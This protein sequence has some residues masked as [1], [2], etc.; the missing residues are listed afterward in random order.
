MRRCT[1][2]T[3]L[4]LALGSAA[5]ALGVQTERRRTSTVGSR[6]SGATPV[7]TPQHVMLVLGDSI[8]AGIGASDPTHRGFAAVFHGYLERHMGR[9]V[10][11]VN[12]A[13][14]GETTTSFIENGQLNDARRLLEDARASGFTIE[15]LLISLGGN[16]LI[17]AG[18][19]WNALEA[20]L[21]T[22]SNNLGHILPSLREPLAGGVSPNL[23]ALTYYDPSGSNPDRQGA[24]AWWVARLNEAIVQSTQM[25]GGRAPDLPT[26][27]RGRE[28]E[29]TWSPTD[30]HPTNSGHAEI[31]RALWTATGYDTV[32]PAVALIRPTPGPLPRPLPTIVAS[33]ADTVGVERVVAV[34]DGSEI[35]EL[36]YHQVAQAYLL[37]WDTRGLSPGDHHL[38][39]RATDAAGNVGVGAVTVQPALEAAGAPVMATPGC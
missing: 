8:A 37:L 38:E 14:P 16:D 34:V 19:D 2:R 25:V 33:A 9:P 26:L 4:R 10:D 27:F 12:L 20:A 13:R 7:G 17:K 3:A 11:L 6:L 23:L 15:P 22:A 35:G 21:A 1:R 36:V 5:L 29:L 39:V 28:D 32:S 24:N 31:A 18:G 30:V